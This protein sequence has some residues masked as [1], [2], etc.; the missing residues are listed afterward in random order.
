MKAPTV[1]VIDFETKGIEARPKYPPIPVGVSIQKPGERK[2]KY[3]AWGHPTGNNCDKNT[4]RRAVMEAYSLGYPLLGQNMK[5]DIDVAETHL[6]CPRPSWENI[7]DTLYL[8]FLADPHAQTYSL[9][10]AAK[11]FLGMEPDEQTAVRDWLVEHGVVRK[12]DQKWGA[13]IADAPGDLVGKYADGD[14]VRT[15]ALFKHLMPRICDAGMQQA[16]DRERRLM[17]IFLENERRGLRIDMDNL[18]KDIGV[19]RKAHTA[20][21]QWIRKRLKAPDLNLD[22]DDD[23]A[24]ALH[25]A[26]VVTD[27]ELTKTGKRSVSKK[28]MTIHKFSDKKVFYTLGYRN[29]LTT[30]LSMFMEPWFEKGS[31]NKGFIN[32]N[33]NQVRQSKTENGDASGTRTGRPSC[34]DPNLLNVSK[35]FYDRGDSYTHPSFIK[36]LPELPLVRKYSLPDKNEEWLHR[37]Y[38]QQELRILAHFEDGAILQAYK[39]DPTLDIHSFVQAEIKRLMHRDIDR[40][41]VKTMNFGKLY[42]QGLGSLAEKLNVSVDEVKSIRDSQNKALPGLK[43]L[44]DAIKDLSK[45]GEPIVTW[46]GRVYYVEPPKYVEKFKREMT[47]EYKLLNYLVQGSAADV[48]KEAIIRHDSVRKDSRFL[49]TVYDEINISAPKRA[50]KSE[51]R[52]LKDIMEGV[53]LDVPMLSDGKTGPSWGSLTKYKE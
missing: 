24:E 16:Y 29:R 33:W 8:I 52:I 6:D 17:P 42:G 31:A 37:D 12:N 41:S 35:S 30:C 28:T 14:C 47:F 3:Y 18:E 43:G 1:T 40:V 11:R 46:G 20:A 23:V 9:K 19:Y 5:F 32:P 36:S 4:G 38:N 44:E 34:N 10:P 53:E 13:H 26:G 51:M 50:V 49:V 2:P 27:W 21:E 48:T 22:A 39:D 7:H 15:L 45:S 25:Q